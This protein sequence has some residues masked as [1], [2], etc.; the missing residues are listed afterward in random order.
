[1]VKLQ[2][3]IKLTGNSKYIEKY[4]GWIYYINIVLVSEKKPDIL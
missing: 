1:L 2:I 4:F 3:T